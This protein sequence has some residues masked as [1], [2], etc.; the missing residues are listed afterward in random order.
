MA[1]T[2]HTSALLKPSN[3]QGHHLAL[4][5]RKVDER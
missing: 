4:A 2:A 1:K 5:L 3:A